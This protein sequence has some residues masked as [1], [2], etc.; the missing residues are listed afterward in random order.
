MRFVLPGKLEGIGWYSYETARRMALMHPE[1]EFLFLFDRPFSPSLV[2]GEN[3]TGYRIRP[4]ARHP[5]L[6]Y[7]WFEWS[8]PRALKQLKADVFFSPD[9][10][11]SLKSDVPTLMV[12]HDLAFEH[13]SHHVS[14]LVQRFYRYFSPRYARRA[15]HIATVSNASRLDLMTRYGVNPDKI[16]VVYN[17]ANTQFEPLDPQEQAKARQQYTDGTPYFVYVG[18]VHPRKNLVRLLQAFDQFA[19]QNPEQNLLIAGRMAWKTGPVEALLRTMRH[20][21]RVYFAGHLEP[22]ALKAVLGSA[23][24]LLY[25]SLFEGF[26]I[27]I[28][29]AFY[30]EVAVLTSNCSSMPEVAGSAAELVDPTDVEDIA[31]GMN[32]LA[33]DPA[34]RQQLIQAGRHER[35]RFSWD[36]TAQKTWQAL[37]KVMPR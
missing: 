19:D 18:S 1:H 2:D 20:R 34:Y 6:W 16:D 25:P 22:E 31:R 30:A 7:A 5:F 23:T 13:Y 36:L 33:N 32:R 26:G 3:V 24:A 14:G 27:P 9:G 35:Q 17:G 28:V 10:F 12:V 37:E 21:S 29:E 8:I 15:E 4:Q 11:C